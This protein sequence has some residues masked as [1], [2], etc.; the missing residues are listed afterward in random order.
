M[1]KKI[2]NISMNDSHDQLLKDQANVNYKIQS[3][4]IAVA[5]FNLRLSN[6]LNKNKP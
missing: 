6:V 3:Q 1:A 5:K 4:L 2:L